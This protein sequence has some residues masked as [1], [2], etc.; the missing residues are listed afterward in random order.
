MFY[1]RF[2]NQML[3]NQFD[4]VHISA[5][6]LARIIHKLFFSPSPQSPVPRLLVAGEG[7]CYEHPDGFPAL[8]RPKRSAW[9]RESGG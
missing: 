6:M 2:E 9:E 5:G 7:N 1:S 3:K 8:P 4:M